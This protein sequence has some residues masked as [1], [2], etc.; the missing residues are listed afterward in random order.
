MCVSAMLAT[1]WLLVGYMWYKSVTRQ[2]FSVHWTLTI[3]PHDI[4]TEL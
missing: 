1:A 2:L 3:I 4:N